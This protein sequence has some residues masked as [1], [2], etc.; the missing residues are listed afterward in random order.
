MF[1]FDLNEILGALTKRLVVKR[2]RQILVD[3]DIASGR[4]CN[5]LLRNPVLPA[6]SKI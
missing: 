4:I 5:P 6:S 2:K 1:Y 3:V